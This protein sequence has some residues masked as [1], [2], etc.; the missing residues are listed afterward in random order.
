MYSA[1]LDNL[2]SATIKTENKPDAG[3]AKQPNQFQIDARSPAV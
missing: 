2:F 3:P 1:P